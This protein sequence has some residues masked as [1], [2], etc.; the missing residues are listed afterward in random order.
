MSGQYE[1]SWP[2][3]SSNRTACLTDLLKRNVFVDVTLVFD[4]DQVAAHKVILSSASSF[5]QS[6]LE[7]NPHPNP[8]LYMKGMEKRLFSSLLE[9]IYLGEVSLPEK[10]FDQFIAMARD[11]K[12]KGLLNDVKGEEN[13]KKKSD[14]KRLSS[15][16]PKRE[17]LHE[18]SLPPSRNNVS[19]N[20]GT[21][22]PMALM[23]EGYDEYATKVETVAA[24]DNKIQKVTSSVM[25]KGKKVVSAAPVNTT[26]NTVKKEVRDIPHSGLLDTTDTGD[27]DLSNPVSAE[28]FA[29]V[30]ALL[31][32][33][34]EG[35][36]V[37][38]ECR[39]GSKSKANVMEHAETHIEGI[40]HKCKF[41]NRVFTKKTSLKNH[42]NKC[43]AAK[44]NAATDMMSQSN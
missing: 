34:P 7:K 35:F 1:V 9:F 8:M 10:D 40:V 37:C 25:E 17:T 43:A 33:T 2:D 13:D 30:S 16:D 39:Y 27:Y 22:M 38:N 32:T 6:V 14:D 4:D 15:K 42:L 23:A 41:C 3:Y 29:K 44:R 21:P 36:W 12:I 31:V 5:F 28:I 11:L 19:S 18:T 20:V 24:R 26:S